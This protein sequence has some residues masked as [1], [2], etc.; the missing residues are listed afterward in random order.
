[1]LTPSTA[2]NFTEQWNSC[3]LLME[4]QNNATILENGLTVSYEVKHILIIW[5]SNFSSR[6]L[7]KRN[8]ILRL[9]IF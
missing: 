6:Y 2:G 1:M 7:P 4:M 5:T 8:K 3:E 9:Y